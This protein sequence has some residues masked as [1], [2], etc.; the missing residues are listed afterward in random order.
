VIGS[1]PTSATYGGTISIGTAQPQNIK[2]VSLVRPMA[3]T[4]SYDS[5]QRLVDVP[6]TSK[7]KTT[8]TATIPTNR[9]LA[10]PGWYML[11]INHNNGAPSA[12][13]WIQ[14]Q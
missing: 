6:I 3:T 9:N 5:E 10:P 2:W 4:H 13:S 7:T 14:L 11:F 1:A 8:L 12:A